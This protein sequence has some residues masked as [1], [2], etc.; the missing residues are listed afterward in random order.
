MPMRPRLPTRTEV[1]AR[2]GQC[3]GASAKTIN[4]FRS[5]ETVLAADERGQDPDRAEP[6][7]CQQGASERSEEGV[8]QRDDVR[9][10]NDGVARR[11]ERQPRRCATK[12]GEDGGG[13]RHAEALTHDACGGEQSGCFA[14]LPG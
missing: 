11:R 8:L 7:T 12:T 6:G 9:G 14:L 10:R 3:G 4:R 13:E 1:S 2:T 5:R